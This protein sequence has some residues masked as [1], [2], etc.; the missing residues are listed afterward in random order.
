MQKL[1]EGNTAPLSYR[2]FPK[3]WVPSYSTSCIPLITTKK[4]LHVYFSETHEFS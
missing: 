3:C 1:N 2:R 4:N